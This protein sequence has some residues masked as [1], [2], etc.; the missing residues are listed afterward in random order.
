VRKGIPA[1]IA[2]QFEISDVAAITLANEFYA[3]VADGFPVDGALSEARKAIFTRV[4]AVEWATPVLYM[5]SPDGRIFE[6]EDQDERLATREMRRLIVESTPEA[7]PAI[8]AAEPAPQRVAPIPEG[9]ATERVK[10]R[11]VAPPPTAPRPEPKPVQPVRPRPAG[12]LWARH[13]AAILGAVAAAVALAVALAFLLPRGATN[14]PRGPTG[15]ETS[16][17][18]GNLAFVQVP[19]LGIEG[20]GQG[21]M[22]RVIPSTTGSALVGVGT[23][24]A[25]WLSDDAVNW[26]RKQVPNVE[27]GGS[28]SIFGV[29]EGGPGLVA[30]GG[31]KPAGGVESA[32]VWTS[33]DGSNW[34]PVPSQDD[35][36]WHK[37][38]RMNRV[39][40]VAGGFVAVGVRGDDA[41]LW[42]SADGKNWKYRATPGMRAHDDI[43]PQLRGIDVRSARI[44]VVGHENRANE[45]G[46]VVSQH[47]AVWVSRDAGANWKKASMPTGS[48][49]QSVVSVSSLG[50]LLVAVGFDG[51]A[52]DHDWAAWTSP[53]GRTWSSVSD[54]EKLRR[55]GDQ[56]LRGIVAIE[57]LGFV[58]VGIDDQDAA[59]LTSPDGMSW[60]LL[61]SPGGE[62]EQNVMSIIESSVGL[63]AVGHD[64]GGPGVWTAE[65]PPR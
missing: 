63:V 29:A 42:V 9:V 35:L 43:R 3:A 20:S 4:N 45:D 51:T 27:G 55:P 14:G 23:G 7:E 13:R 30:V 28:Q 15:P 38:S 32:A 12:G 48:Q 1:V 64:N 36:R 62:G 11:E 54:L 60:S 56:A 25:V 19:P 57:G 39:A 61:T 58:A 6:I 59:I 49:E 41:G 33:A 37:T 24:G 26:D 44:V 8:E 5:R 18:I 16:P 65:L 40:A 17:G 2:M 52:D 50:G 34:E 31:Q 47:A 53:D 21:G 46:D 22:N 10:E